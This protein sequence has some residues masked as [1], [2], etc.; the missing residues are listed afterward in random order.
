MPDCNCGNQHGHAH[1]CAIFTC[2]VC[3]AAT[4][5]AP[6]DGPAFCEAHCPDHDYQYERGEGHRCVK[7]NAEPPLDWHDES[8]LR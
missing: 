3:G 6:K 2:S 1:N 8:D 7:C 5:I 4:S